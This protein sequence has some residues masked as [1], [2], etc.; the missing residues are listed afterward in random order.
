MPNY[1]TR[2]ILAVFLVLTFPFDLF[3]FN[4]P[5]YSDKVYIHP[6]FEIDIDEIYL[7]ILKIC[8]KK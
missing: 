5:S 6:N 3:Y 8:S 7:I 4:I 2:F 1:D